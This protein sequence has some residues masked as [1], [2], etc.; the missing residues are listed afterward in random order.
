MQWSMKSI[1]ASLGLFL[2]AQLC[3]AQIPKP[4]DAPKP[5][6]PDESAAAFKLPE[7]FRMEAV[8]SEPLIASPTAVCWD[9]RGRMFVSELHGY[10]LEGQLEIEDLNKTGKL[11]TQVRR[12]EAAEKYKQA[13]K[14]GTYGVVKMLRDTDGDGRMDAAETW[15]N[16]LPPAYGVVPAR[17]GVIVACAP[18]IVYLADSKGDGKADR[19]EVLFTGFR[20]GELWRGINAPQWGA[21][22]W[23]YFG[24]GWGGSRITG[25]KLAKAVDLPDS[26]FRIRADGSAIEPVTGATHTFG[27]ATTE[28]GDRF[29]VNTTIPA[30][31]IA[32]LPWRYLA[33][34]PDAAA[35]GTRSSDR[36]LPRVVAF[37]ATSLAQTPRGGSRLFQILQL[38]IRRRGERGRWLVY[39]GLRAA[40]LS[41]PRTAGIARAVFCLRAL[42]ESHSS[43]AHPGRWRAFERASRAGRGEI[44][45]RRNPRPVEPSDQSHTRTGRRDLGHGLLSRDHRG[46]LGD[47]APSSATVRRL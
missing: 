19:R 34:N 42:G 43:R 2:A 22:G 21:D 31:Q 4:T 18:D 27:F 39:C 3:F 30:I 20:T 25:P 9:E 14:A 40:G 24:R 46:L 38:E 1:L 6:T 28:S 15:A 35:S 17:G 23:I 11:D 5:M 8:A 37:R 13:A 36:R 10:N 29:T 16:D 45:I 33:R 12:V 26:D 44:G 32:P 47:S 7:G 41:R